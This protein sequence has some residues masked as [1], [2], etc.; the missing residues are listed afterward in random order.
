MTERIRTIRDVMMDASQVQTLY[1]IAK[2]QEIS[3]HV[4]QYVEI[5][6]KWEMKF[7]TQESLRVVKNVRK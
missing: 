7:V 3:V 6:S 2:E 5:P 1:G 4:N